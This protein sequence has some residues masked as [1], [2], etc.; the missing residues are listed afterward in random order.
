MNQLGFS[1]RQSRRGGFFGCSGRLIFPRSGAT[2]FAFASLPRL[3][4]AL[5]TEKGFPIIE[6]T[7]GVSGYVVR[8]TDKGE[9]TFASKHFPEVRQRDR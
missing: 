9:E 1:G 5:G 7:K 6:E 3:V 4:A 8:K 2:I